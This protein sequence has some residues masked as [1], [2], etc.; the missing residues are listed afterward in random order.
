MDGKTVIAGT[1]VVVFL[2]KSETIP[3]N[4]VKVT[5]PEIFLESV[6]KTLLVAFKHETSKFLLYI[7]SI[8]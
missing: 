2:T 8:L 6:F 4:L 1:E 5:H 3:R 7:L